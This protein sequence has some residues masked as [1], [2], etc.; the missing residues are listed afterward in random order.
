L[1]VRE[2][3]FT[4][5]T[6]LPLSEI[7][8]DALKRVADAIQTRQ[9]TMLQLDLASLRTD[10][11]QLPWVREAYV[12][13]QFPASIVVSIEEHKPSATWIADSIM[14]V[15]ADATTSTQ[16][17]LVNSYGE[18]FN[19]VISDER[20]WLL[21]QLGGPEGSSTEVLAKFAALMPPL[22]TIEH[23]PTKLMLTAR[24]AWQ[25]TLANGSELQLGRGETE[26]RLNRFIQAYP[27]VAAL[28]VANSG[29][30][31]RYQ[32]GFTIRNNAS[33]KSASQNAGKKS[34]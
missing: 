28:Q 17:L 11:K 4:S 19:A 27:Q 22:K 24:R 13:R 30:D 15:V 31:L 9:A 14:P 33:V 29:V 7:E 26:E 10:I 21:P 6:S 1:P 16:S 23:T 8:N 32:S 5:S 3:I 25:V 2:V 34:L 12:R 18:L 20:K